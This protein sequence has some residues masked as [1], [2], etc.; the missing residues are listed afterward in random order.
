M[1]KVIGKFLLL[2]I[3]IEVSVNLLKERCCRYIFAGVLVYLLPIL[4]TSECISR[5]IVK[6]FKDRFLE[7]KRENENITGFFSFFKEEYTSDL[8]LDCSA[9]YNIKC[10][11]QS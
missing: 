10:L 1:G 7:E 4:L 8:K 11:E 3:R 6:P 5:S 9:T 2:Y